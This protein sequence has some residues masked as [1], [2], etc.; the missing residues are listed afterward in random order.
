MIVLFGGEEKVVDGVGEIVV[1]LLGH[2]HVDGTEPSPHV[3]HL[4]ANLLRRERAV[5]RE[6]HVTNGGDPSENR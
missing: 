3:R 6:V 5:D 2:R 4:H 1:D